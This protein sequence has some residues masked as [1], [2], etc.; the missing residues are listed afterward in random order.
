LFF[1]SNVYFNG[2]A[3]GTPITTVG[4][5]GAAAGNSGMHKMVGDATVT[6]FGTVVVGGGG[7][8]VPV[9]SDNVNWR[10]G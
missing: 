10:I 6:T 9:Y 4:A 3:Y 2:G 1:S 7:N 5:L 8:T